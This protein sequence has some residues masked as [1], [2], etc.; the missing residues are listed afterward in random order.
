MSSKLKVLMGQINFT[1]GDLEGNYNKIK[2]V[3]DE[4]H[5]K[6]DM[7][8]FSELCISGYPPLD[9]VEKD[10][11]VDKQNEYIE[12]LKLYSIRLNCAIVIGYIGND[13]Y[14]DI[15][16][17]SGKKLS[18][19]LMVLHKGVILGTYSK[20]L[21]PTYN[22]FDESRYFEPGD[23]SLIIYF[24]GEKIAFLICEDCWYTESKHP[25]YKKDPVE[26]LKDKDINLLITINASP[27]NTGK[28]E[29]R[30]RIM[31]DVWHK[32]KCPI[33]YVNQVG[34]ND[35]IIFDG[36]SI[37]LD[38]VMMQEVEVGAFID[39]SEGYHF[40][41]SEV[42]YDFEAGDNINGQDFRGEQYHINVELFFAHIVMGIR[43]YCRKTGF[44]KV[45]IGESGGIDSAVVTAVAKIALGAHN[46]E[47]I[48]MPTNYS[49]DGSVN[50]SVELCKNLGVKL[51]NR[52]IQ[53]EFELS[54]ENFR[55]C[56]EQI[57]SGLTKENM[58]AR[59]R[60]RILMEFSNHFGH[61]VLS[62][63]NKT[64]V[65]VGYCTLYGDTNGGI[66]PISDLYKMEVYALARYI[67]EKY[68]MELIP[69]SII[70][71][72]PSAELSENQK[73]SDN[74]PPYPILDAMVRREI[75]GDLLS[76]EEIKKDNDL[77]YWEHEGY[78]KVRRLIK[79]AEYKRR[80][81]PPTIR[82]HARAWGT[83]RQYP[84]ASKY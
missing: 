29:Q 36:G 5:M 53:D 51:Y 16:G 12:K 72:E 58:Q 79:I 17:T 54:N 41:E 84:I 76:E 63:G 15:L 59:I 55:R 70:D 81:T 66:A 83:G 32:I 47:A 75:E 43:D 80:Q 6:C 69:Q 68:D 30:H 27:S 2:K 13:T 3:L 78:N 67:N 77:F 60:G 35:D 57:P 20:Q 21:L 26:E 45:V 7:A 52:P 50:D 4:N 56:F 34:G 74:L 33:V 25:L 39:A 37:V 11:F 46:V 23:E 9:L 24:K 62:T 82:C 8:V 10:G 19:S 64:E 65:A 49:S 40:R 1:V 61:L 42:I 38:N 73:D 71:K 31:H 14:S 22:I 48:T 18:N 44:T 28:I